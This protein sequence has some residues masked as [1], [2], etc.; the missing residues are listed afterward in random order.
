MFF[1]CNF[2]NKKEEGYEKSNFEW[3][4]FSAVEFLQ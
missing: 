2:I 4:C 1:D 3:T